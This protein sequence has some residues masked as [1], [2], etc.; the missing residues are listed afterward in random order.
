V[1]LGRY[2]WHFSSHS[3]ALNSIPISL[4]LF[5]KLVDPHPPDFGGS[6]GVAWGRPRPA[7]A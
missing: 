6:F 4:T 7:R 3:I 5:F 1:V 2:F